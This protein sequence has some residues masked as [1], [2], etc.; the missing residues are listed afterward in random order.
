[1]INILFY[2]GIVVIAGVLSIMYIMLDKFID[3]QI[4]LYKAEKEGITNLNWF[5][6]YELY[7]LDFTEGGEDY[8]TKTRYL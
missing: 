8:A 6:K 3:K 1:M 5:L 7:R 4:M 2:S